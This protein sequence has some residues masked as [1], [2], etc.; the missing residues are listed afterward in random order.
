MALTDATEDG[1][2]EGYFASASDLMVG[3]LFVFLLMLTVFALNFRDAE[4]EVEV[5]AKK[6]KEQEAIAAAQRMQN[7]KLR[8]LLRETVVR[9]ERDIEDRTAARNRLLKALKHSLEDRGVSVSIDEKSGILR[10]P[11]ELLFKVRESFIPEEKRPALKELSEVLAEILPCY[12]AN[13]GRFISCEPGG[14]SILEAVL[15]EGHA[16]TQGYRNLLPQ[17]SETLNDRLS[18]E[19]ALNVFEALWAN[20]S[21]AALHNA[22]SLPLLGVSGYGSRRPLP[23]AQGT[24]QEDFRKNRRIDLRFVLSAR[25]PEDVKGLSDEIQRTLKEAQ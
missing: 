23:D 19:R 4:N 1:G 9:L 15:I 18:T 5:Q 8:Q 24:T 13:Q 6:A 14:G 16:D 21:L 11:E 20:P 3:I 7:D 12:S 25:T 2:G 17:A 10:L 22:E